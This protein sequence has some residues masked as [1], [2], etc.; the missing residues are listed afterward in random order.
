MSWFKRIK[1]GITTS[2]KEKKETP[3]G[4]W[5]KCT[6][7]KHIT[8]LRTTRPIM[9]VC[10]QCGYHDRIGSAEYFEILFDENT[11]SR[12]LPRPEPPKTRSNFV[13]T[14]KYTDRIKETQRKSGTQGRDPH[15]CR[16][17]EWRRP[18]DRLYGLQL[19]RRLDGL[20]WSARRSP[21]PSTTAWSTG[22]AVA[23][24]QQIRRRPHDGSR[25]FPDAD[26]QDLRQT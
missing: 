7:C 19:H 1:E 26:G 9:Y 13:D 6:S 18:G 8:L 12:T 14:K 2:T 25:L 5:H 11:S 16:Q 22:C 10:D 24:H 23:R 21:A 4:L 3:E 17:S 20:V 15:R